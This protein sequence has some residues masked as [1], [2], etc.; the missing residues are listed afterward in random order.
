[1]NKHIKVRISRSGKNISLITNLS[2]HNVAMIGFEQDGVV[3]GG[4]T[5]F[6]KGEHHN[7]WVSMYIGPGWKYLF[8]RDDRCYGTTKT[9]LEGLIACKRMLQYFIDN[10]M[11]EHDVIEVSGST[12]QRDIIYEQGLKSMG[13]KYTSEYNDTERIMIFIKDS[14]PEFIANN[15]G[16]L[17]WN[18]DNAWSYLKLYGVQFPEHPYFDDNDYFDEFRCHYLLGILDFIH[19]IMKCIRISIIEY[20]SSKLECLW[21]DIKKPFI[22][23][24]KRHRCNGIQN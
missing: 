8:S 9:P 2:N 18:R 13:F 11:E 5:P 24:S 6:F 3:L 16:E 17:V 14:T 21:Y 15:D 12:I 4:Y 10:I 22:N 19:Y 7:W 1:M 23:K 20:L